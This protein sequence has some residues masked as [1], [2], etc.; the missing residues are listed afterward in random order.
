LAALSVI[1]PPGRV[2]GGVAAE[3]MVADRQARRATHFTFLML[4][5][6]A[7]GRV[8]LPLREVPRP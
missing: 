4:Q 8:S 7:D 1:V 2:F 3:A 6:R 5:E